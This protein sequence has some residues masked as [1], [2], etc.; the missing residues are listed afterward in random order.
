M[1]GINC[2]GMAWLV[3]ML[4]QHEEILSGS[5]NVA[6][7]LPRLS[8]PQ[9]ALHPPRPASATAHAVTTVDN[10]SQLAPSMDSKSTEVGE[11]IQHSKRGYSPRSD[12]ENKAALE[13]ARRLPCTAVPPVAVSDTHTLDEKHSAPMWPADLPRRAEL[14]ALR[15]AAEL[16]CARSRCKV[17][18]MH[19]HKSG[20]STLCALAGAN[21]M[22]VNLQGN[23]QEMDANGQRV[24][25]W[26]RS[27]LEQSE[28]FRSSPHEFLANEDNPF[29]SPPL[30]GAILYVITIR[31]PLDRILSHFRHHRKDH[32]LTNYSF[33]TFAASWP[34]ADY[35]ASNWY[36]QLLGGGAASADPESSGPRDARGRSGCFGNGAQCG[37]ESLGAALA[38]LEGYFSAVLLTD[39]E[40]H[41]RVGGLLLRQTLGW[42]SR[43]GTDGARRGTRVEVSV[44]LRLLKTLLGLHTTTQKCMDRYFALVHV[45]WSAC[46]EPRR[47]RARQ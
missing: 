15:T 36:V 30:P 35:W 21:G 7:P 37:A 31:Q 46:T 13:T 17:Y 8:L 33:S 41:F 4:V 27:A 26:R 38:R 3:F 6:I 23:C 12:N 5:H 42:T 16:R 2:V 24:D 22:A 10:A 19:T 1:L 11:V 43:L 44:S 47:G 29:L 14:I 45:R 20:G 28:V 25:W 39:S 18:Y 32:K 34:P 9:G 40:L